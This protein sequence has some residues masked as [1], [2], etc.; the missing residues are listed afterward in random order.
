MGLGGIGKIAK[1]VVGGVKGAGKAKKGK[2]GKK[3]KGNPL[4]KVKGAAD[5]VTGGGV[6]KIKDGVGLA[7]AI[8]DKDAGGI[9]SS[10]SGL[11]GF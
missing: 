3:K 4:D 5:V 2:K 8:K 11:L 9:A 7:G 6:G 1:G 10:A